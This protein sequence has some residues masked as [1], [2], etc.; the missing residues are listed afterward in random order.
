MP[1]YGVANGRANGVYDNWQDCKDQ[2]H[3][4]SYNKYK[5]FDTPDQ[6][7]DF[8]DQHSSSGGDQF[9][10]QSSS[11]KAITS[12]N[13]QQLALKYNSGLESRSFQ[14]TDYVEGQNG[15]IMRE[16]TFT[17]GR[18]GNGYFVEK[19]IRTYWEN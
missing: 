14:R 18:S 7:W 16:R 11:R 5:K 17:S 9:V 1:Y 12:G 3:G 8:V 19:R 13:N 15:V 4:Y 2:V 10:Q 6:A